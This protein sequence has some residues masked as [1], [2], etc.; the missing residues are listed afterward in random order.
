M[1]RGSRKRSQ[2]LGVRRW[3][4]LVADKKKWKDI[5]RQAKDTVGCSANERRR[6]KRRRNIRFLSV[7][8]YKA[9]KTNEQYYVIH[10]F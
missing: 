2:V 6:R 9:Q 7:Q 1:E 8:S 10:T 4:D 3:G 5:V